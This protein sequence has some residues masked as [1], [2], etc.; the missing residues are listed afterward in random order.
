[1]LATPNDPYDGWK[2]PIIPDPNASGTVE[3]TGIQCSSGAVV[4]FC[5]SNAGCDWASRLQSSTTKLSVDAGRHVDYTGYMVF[6]GPGL[7]RLT[8]SDAKSVVARV[9]IEVPQ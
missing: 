4:R 9:V 2:V 8:V 1:V 5:Y 7:I 6:P 3:L